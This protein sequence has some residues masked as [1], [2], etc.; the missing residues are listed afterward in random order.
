MK[1]YKITKFTMSDGRTFM[2]EVDIETGYRLHT[3]LPLTSDTDLPIQSYKYQGKTLGEIFEIDPE[4]VKWLLHGSKA[5]KRIKKA[6]RRILDGNPYIV[7]PEGT[8][9]NEN[10]LYEFL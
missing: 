7:Q 5:S 9:I 6:C 8:I 2:R 1:Q 4:Y 10:Q 3:N